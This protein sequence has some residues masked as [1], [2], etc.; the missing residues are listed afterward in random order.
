MITGEFITAFRYEEDKIDKEILNTKLVD[1]ECKHVASRLASQIYEAAIASGY[2]NVVLGSHR[3]GTLES[4]NC[5]INSMAKDSYF[6]RPIRIVLGTDSRL[7]CDNT[8]SAI[9]Y[10][11]RYDNSITL[12]DV[13]FYLIDISERIPLIVSVSGTV[14]Q[15]V[16][17]IKNAIACALRINNRLELGV[18]PE[19]MSWTIGDLKKDIDLLMSLVC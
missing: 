6:N 1:L 12:A 16:T 3:K 7:W 10:L 11:R 4:E 17:D 19:N 18:R 13:P 14:I 2:K 9:A 8:H 15:S 5:I